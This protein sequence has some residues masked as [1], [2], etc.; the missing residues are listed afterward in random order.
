M[1]S[2]SGK[3]FRW[4][5]GITGFLV[6]LGLV[7]IGWRG[8]WGPKW[9]WARG[10]PRSIE[11]WEND[12][13]I[14][15]A[16]AAAAVGILLA[17]IVFAIQKRDSDR[18]LETTVSEL[19]G[20]KEGLDRAIRRLGQEISVLKQIETTE[21][22]ISILRGWFAPDAGRKLTH[23]WW[24][25]GYSVIPVFWADAQKCD[26]IVRLICDIGHDGVSLVGPQEEV[27]EIFA[28]AAANAFL[29][30]KHIT[31]ERIARW[32]DDFSE[33]APIKKRI[34]EEYRVFIQRCTDASPGGAGRF[35]GHRNLQS[36][37]APGVN[38]AI[39]KFQGD[40]DAEFEIIVFRDQERAEH[41]LF[42]AKPT[43]HVTNNPTL[44]EL[45]IQEFEIS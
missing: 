18:A 39:A 13:I 30:N 24:R 12:L 28:T 15:C 21:E 9:E 36:R 43:V 7:Y 17:I 37:T 33:M 20:T 1:S 23:F 45:I 5:L 38:W 2:P 41:P 29:R 26:E 10:G 40:E 25:S 14:L 3:I 44:A 35:P 16:N 32:K 34:T 4:I 22:A 27:F 42:L 6:Y 19:Q 31:D 8:W 11:S